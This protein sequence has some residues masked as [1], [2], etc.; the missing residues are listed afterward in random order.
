MPF[1]HFDLS[2]I[3][4]GP[5]G[6]TASLESLKYGLSVCLFEENMPGGALCHAW[7]IDNIPFIG[8]G[9]SGQMI[10]SHFQKMVESLPLVYINQ[11]V[12]GIYKEGE[13]FFMGGIDT[14]YSSTA[15]I[16]A[17]GLCPKKETIDTCLERFLVNSW[18]IPPDK[19]KRCLLVGGGD[20]CFDRALFLNDMGFDVC[21]MHR[22][23][24]I[25]NPALVKEARGKRLKIIHNDMKNLYL[26]SDGFSIPDNDG[27]FG[28]LFLY[29]GRQPCSP[30][31]TLNG[32]FYSVYEAQATE[33]DG[34]FWAGDI[35][36]DSG[37]NAVNAAS[38]GL[39]AAHRA[40]KY[41]KSKK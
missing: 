22:G 15:I 11:K 35:L 23:N 36:P 25:A 39:L 41:I 19:E 30:L 5:A 40:L 12:K 2:V 4:A 27:V 10:K 20:V 28:Y 32:I 14:L 37:R 26:N 7:R 18:D 16:I 8:K 33:N 29:T 24:I 13:L 9:C 34:L 21:I 17:T 1:E 3:G 31:I 38:D 6:V